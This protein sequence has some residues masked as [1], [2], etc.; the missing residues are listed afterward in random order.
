MERPVAQLQ[1]ARQVFP[2]VREQTPS[3]SKYDLQP[4]CILDLRL[5]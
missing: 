1:A 5:H 3:D 2:L 4:I